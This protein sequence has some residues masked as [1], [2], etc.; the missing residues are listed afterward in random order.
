LL[1]SPGWFRTCYLSAS[2]SR[3]LGLQRYHL[4][5]GSHNVFV[6]SN[7]FLVQ[8]SGDV[9]FFHLHI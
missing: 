8:H 6:L 9:T 3:V 4:D 2:A 5:L 7:L 1:S